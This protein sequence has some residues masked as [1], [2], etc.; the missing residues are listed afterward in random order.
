MRPIDYFD[1]GAEA[2]PERVAFEGNGVTYCYADA[3][4]ESEAIA[5]ALYAAG[6]APRDACAVFAPNDPR[7]MIA[8]LGVLR[9]GGAWVPVNTRNAPAA[10]AEYM[11]YVGTRWLLYHSAVAAEVAAMRPMLTGL[12]G[13]V[14]LDRECD[15]DPSL[16]D[17]IARGGD[18]AIPDWSDP[19]SSPDH[20]LAL[21]PTGGTTGPSKGV[22]ITNRAWTAMIEM[23]MHYWDIGAPPVCLAVAPITHAAGGMALILAGLSATNV[24]LP[25]FDAGEVLAAIE[26][27]RVTHMFLPPTALYAL[28]A[29]PRVRDVDTSSLRQLL[30]AAAPVSPDKLREAVEV[31]GPCICQCY[32]QAE[33]P[34]LLAWLPPATL[35]AAAR[36]EHPER[37]KSCG[38]ATSGCRV[39]IMDDEGTLLP[40]GERGEIVA[41]GPLVTPGYFAKPEATAEIRAHGWHHTGDVGYVDTDGYLYIVDRKKDMIIT[42]GFNVYAA[43]VEAPI[44][45]LPAVKECAV[46]GVPDPVWGEAV[47]AIVVA[48]AGMALDARTVIEHCRTELGPVKTPKSVDFRDEIP[49]TANGK[50]DKKALRAEYWEGRD[51][52]VN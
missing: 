20:P 36:G 35:A 45:A 47:K 43:E 49:R 2:A 38:R 14:C 52:S 48:K 12:R 8:V 13:T 22:F 42:G 40:P 5:R 51:R 24:I 29:H 34:F 37:L 7:A 3:R 27:H 23:G 9:A 4:A 46:I 11:A 1:R 18:G 25:G 19:F 21:W 32:G 10:N 16:A 17:F 6:F 30:V 41:R 28:L 26:R 50:T 33:S 15:G 44:L 39:A 31:F